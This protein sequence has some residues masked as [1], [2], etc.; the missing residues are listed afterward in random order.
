MNEKGPAGPEVSVTGPIT[1]ALFTGRGAKE[2]RIEWGAVRNVA[3]AY[4]RFVF[5]KDVSTIIFQTLC[6]RS[7]RPVRSETRELDGAPPGACAKCIAALPGQET[8]PITIA[9]GSK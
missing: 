5:T 3:H 4:R 1:D 9:G 2:T 8:P 6:G 7:A